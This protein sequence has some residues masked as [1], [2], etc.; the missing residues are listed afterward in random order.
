MMSLLKCKNIG[1]SSWVFC[2]RW[3]LK[4]FYFDNRL[5]SVKIVLM[6]LAEMAINYDQTSVCPVP[7][8]NQSRLN[9]NHL[10]MSMVWDVAETWSLVT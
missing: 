4:I 5:A 6:L 3:L 1:H 10:A 9:I 8:G 7:T 2:V